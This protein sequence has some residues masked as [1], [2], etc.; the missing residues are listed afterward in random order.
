MN[1]HSFLGL[2]H[3][4]GQCTIMKAWINPSTARKRYAVRQSFLCL[5]K[6]FN[7]F[8][9]LGTGSSLSCGEYLEQPE[10]AKCS[11]RSVWLS[12]GALE[13]V[14]GM[15]ALELHPAYWRRSLCAHQTR[16]CYW[17]GYAFFYLCCLLYF[18]LFVCLFSTRKVTHRQRTCKLDL[19]MEAIVRFRRHFVYSRF[20]HF[21]I[22]IV[23]VFIVFVNV[24]TM[25]IIIDDNPLSSLKS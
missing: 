20:S 8:S 16:K 23:I 10:R 25:V 6:L 13:Q 19:G 15:V 5:I 18:C 7:F 1:I 2:A 21:G 9:S 14:R 11:W 22:I 24:I 17:G 4:W 3:L 12:A